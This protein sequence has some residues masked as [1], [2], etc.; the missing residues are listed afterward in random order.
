[1]Y[2]HQAAPNYQADDEM[3]D[4]TITMW[5]SEIAKW[6]IEHARAAEARARRFLKAARSQKNLTP[7]QRVSMRRAA[8]N[9]I[10]LAK[11]RARRKKTEWA[12]LT[13][14]SG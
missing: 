3:D 2:P 4:H 7:E 11:F 5:Q 12:Q 6:E 1:M 13:R 10:A 9:V 8:N 14:Q